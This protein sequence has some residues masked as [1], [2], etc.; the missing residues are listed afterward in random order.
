MAHLVGGDKPDG[1]AIWLTVVPRGP[2]SLDMDRTRPAVV[3]VCKGDSD[4]VRYKMRASLV[5]RLEIVFD[6]R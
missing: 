2:S 4:V 3:S 6:E 1:A 5:D